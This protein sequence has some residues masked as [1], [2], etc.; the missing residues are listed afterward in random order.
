LFALIVAPAAHQRGEEEKSM[1]KSTK[2][3]LIALAV[4][5][6]ALLIF[7]PAISETTYAG[8]SA[9]SG[10]DI[11]KAKCAA[12]H[13]ADGSGSSPMGKKMGLRDLGSAD[14][15]TMSDADLAKITADGKG[16]MPAF[17]SKLSQEEIDAVV[18]HLRTFK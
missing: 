14:V 5:A 7:L 1:S 16:K 11:Y 15:Q 13:A 17:K 12:C 3:L 2:G 8:G 6:A 18:K 4:I 9:A 10:A